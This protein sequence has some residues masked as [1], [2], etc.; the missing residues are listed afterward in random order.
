MNCYLQKIYSLI[1][2]TTRKMTPLKNCKKKSSS[3]HYKIHKDK[4]NHKKAKT[5][6]KDKKHEIQ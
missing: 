3:A 4:L 2:N 6:N 5:R 1:M